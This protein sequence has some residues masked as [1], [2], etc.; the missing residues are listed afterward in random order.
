MSRYSPKLLIFWAG[1]ALRTWHLG[2]AS[3]WIDEVV[4]ANRAHYP[5]ADSLGSIIGAGNQVPFYY[6]LIRSFPT[7]TEMLLRL[8]SAF[9]GTLSI[10]LIML[11]AARLYHDQTVTLLAGAL[12][13]F[14]PF[15]IWLSRMARS[16]ALLIALSLLVSYLFIDLLEGSQSRPKWIAFVLSSAAV[17]LTHDFALILIF[18]Q[19]VVLLVHQ[20]ATPHFTRRWIVAQGIAVAPFLLWFLPIIIIDLLHPGHLIKAAWIPQPHWNDLLLT[21]SNMAAGYDG[22]PSWDYLPALFAAA[23]LLGGG[24]IATFRRADKWSLYWFTLAIPLPL[25]VFL[26]SAVKPLYVDRYFSIG[27]PAVLLLIVSGWR[28]LPRTTLRGLLVGIILLTETSSVGFTLERGRDERTDW[29]GLA[30]HVRDSYQPG[31][32]VLFEADHLREPF[33][34]YSG[35]IDENVMPSLSED[36]GLDVSTF[37]RLWAVYPNPHTNVH[38][39]G[40]LPDFDPFSPGVS[41]MGDWLIAHQTAI[42]QREDFNGIELF[43]VRAHQS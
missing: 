30:A 9:A 3:L 41:P 21:F 28:R 39:Q 20:R 8:P 38:R 40:E 5:L 22:S 29:R 1:F 15:H 7:H 23:I 32:G 12:L 27:L 25:I 43:L 37:A 36:D 4:T 19:L 35:T 24:L 14:S 10:A 18:A 34:Y 31:D 11:I 33:A 42:I 26:A 17:Y 2:A 13:A 6:L 16:Y